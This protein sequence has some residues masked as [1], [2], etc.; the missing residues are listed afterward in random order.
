[1]KRVCIFLLLICFAGCQQPTQ[2]KG[3]ATTAPTNVEP[4]SDAE[5]QRLIAAL[6]A[7]KS[8]TDMNL[9]SKN[10]SEF[11][12]AR[13]VSIEKRI[14]DKLDKQHQKQFTESSG[15]WRR[16]RASEVKFHA[17]FF[18]EGSIQPLIANESY[19]QITQHRVTELEAVLFD[20]HLETQ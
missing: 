7:A 1:M 9:A 19:S 20:S 12:D 15:D 6:N 18:S 10:I 8:Q 3:L 5:L 2:N 14:K 16:Y 11:W 17:D 4:M 13:L